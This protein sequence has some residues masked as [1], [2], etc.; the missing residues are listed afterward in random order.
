MSRLQYMLLLF[1]IFYYSNSLSVRQNVDPQHGA[2]TAWAAHGCTFARV[3]QRGSF[4]APAC[5]KSWWHNGHFSKSCEMERIN[6]CQKYAS[7]GEALHTMLSYAPKRFHQQPPRAV[8]HVWTLS[9]PATKGPSQQNLLREF[10]EFVKESC[11]RQKE[12]DW[13]FSC[14]V[15]PRIR[16]FSSAEAS[17]SKM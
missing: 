2:K 1:I 13:A 17:W 14:T 7:I 8:H 5:R 9:S 10:Y 4:P 3:F 6:K 15:S 12:G 11:G 16:F